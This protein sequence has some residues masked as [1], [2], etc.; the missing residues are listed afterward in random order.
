MRAHLELRL[1][2]SPERT[3]AESLE[4]VLS[5]IA[6]V[7]VARVPW[8][9]DRALVQYDPERTNAPSLRAE[10]ERAGWQVEEAIARS[11]SRPPNDAC[12]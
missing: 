11:R 10:T 12:C 2:S 5:S 1:R 9:G 4:R 6:G 7:H 3:A 8:P